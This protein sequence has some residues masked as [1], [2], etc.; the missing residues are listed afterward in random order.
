MAKWDG[1]QN[2]IDITTENSNV[3]VSVNNTE[4][5]YQMDIQNKLYKNLF[6]IF[7]P[8]MGSSSFP[9]FLY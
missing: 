3:K 6:F 7:Y 9:F 5:F 1:D 8:L 2:L 4:Y